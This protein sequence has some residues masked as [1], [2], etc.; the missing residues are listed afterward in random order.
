MVSTLRGGAV[1]VAAPLLAVAMLAAACSSSSSG[2]G[3]KTSPHSG[4]GTFVVGETAAIQKLDP[5]VATDQQDFQALSLVYQTLVELGPNLQVA[6]YLAT[7][8]H[9]SDG[10]KVLS[11]DLR[12]NVTFD[13]GSPFTSA[14]VKATFDR[15]LKPSTAATGAASF[16]S[17]K[18]VSTPSTY[19][20]DLNLS[21]P[22]SSL[23]QALTGGDFSIE[24]TKAISA[25]TL[26]KTPD[27]TGPYRF[28]S[29]TP[30]ISL[31]LT[32]NP[33]YWGPAPSIGS[34]EFKTIAAEQSIA[35]ALQA[36]TIQMG[37]FAQP[38]VVETL[39]GTDLQVSK[40]LDLNYR[41]LMLQ[42]HGPLAS[43]NA[44]LAMQCAINRAAVLKA[45]VF[46]DGQ[47]VGPDPVGPFASNP[48]SGIC[49]TPNLAAAKSYLA[50]AG[51][52]HGF[53]FTAMTSDALDSTSAAQAV[54]VQAALSKVGIKM[55]IDNVG[56]NDYVQRWLKGDFQAAFAFN[57]SSPS[58]FIM[59]DWYWGKGA[60]FKVPAGYQSPKL[61]SLLA[62]AD[63]SSSSATQKADYDAFSNYLVNNAIWIWLFSAYDY[64][65]TLP[66]V[67]GFVARPD[68]GLESLGTATVS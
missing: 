52:P 53:S 64:Y 58:P 54:T 25:G 31:V 12:K 23:L 14:D 42:D 57:G 1:R 67:H 26:A 35:A 10:N 37:E 33:K 34:I 50:K 56:G 61:R 51:V 46:G 63:E 7:S 49:A 66:T 65:A 21:H 68:D 27:G 43:V 20:V 59:Y 8:W 32:R 15:I 9:L 17:L 62:S 45:S 24:S 22:D 16:A 36:G 11:F 41:V 38:Q 19:V 40:I 30:N 48:A 39:K 47:V 60:P 13:D 55:A 3:G 28:S 29:F 5:D 18:S 44:R 2:S 6:P 4:S